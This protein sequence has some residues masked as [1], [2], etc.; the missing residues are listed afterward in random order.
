MCSL[1]S[2]RLSILANS[3]SKSQAHTSVIT[4]SSYSSVLDASSGRESVGNFAPHSVMVVL[5]ERGDEH[6]IACSSITVDLLVSSSDLAVDTGEL[7]GVVFIYF[8]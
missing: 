6:S 8:S 4:S 1:A 2:I 5:T 3:T 7:S